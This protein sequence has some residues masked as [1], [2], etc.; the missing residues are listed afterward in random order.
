MIIKYDPYSVFKAG[1]SPASLY[2]RKKWLGETDTIE[3]KNDYKKTVSEIKENGIWVEENTIT[4][5]KKLFDLHLTVRDTTPEIKAAV[6]RLLKK[7]ED[8]LI[9]IDKTIITD[10]E[11]ANLPFA[12]GESCLV[13][14]PAALFLAVIFN[15]TQNTSFENIFD[16]MLILS[17]K[18]LSENNNIIFI[19]N[20]FRVLAVNPEYEALLETDSI[21]DRLLSLQTP[22]G[23]WNNIIPFYQAVNAAAHINSEK[24][25]IIFRKALKSII[26]GQNKDGSWGSGELKEWNTFLTVH[27]LKNKSVL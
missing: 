19:H 7:S 3:W 4:S 6:I 25:D 16:K 1:S 26:S 18:T 21:L 20:F 27:A 9:K 22:S 5:V 2:A 23:D 13:I 14:P 8:I 17:N 12:G 10:N 11:T 15:L 24:A